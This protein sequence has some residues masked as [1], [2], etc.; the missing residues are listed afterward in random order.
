MQILAPAKLGAPPLLAAMLVAALVLPARLASAAE[1]ELVSD[2]S[3]S[4]AD[5]PD[6]TPPCRTI[7]QAA[8]A[9]QDSGG[10]ASADSQ[11]QAQA[12]G[13]DENC[14]QSTHAT[15]NG[16][17]RFLLVPQMAE[18]PGDPVTVCLSVSRAI[19]LNTEDGGNARFVTDRISAAA[20]GVVQVA[21]P[22]GAA[23]IQGDDQHLETFNCSREITMRIGEH[24]D[25]A[26]GG[27]A[28][29]GTVGI[30]QSQAASSLLI[31]AQVGT[32]P[33]DFEECTVVL[34]TPAFSGPGLGALGLLL[35][36]CGALM[37]RRRRR[38]HSA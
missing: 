4:N 3:S 11:T 8:S 37:V 32:C 28:T 30:G 38:R 7:A 22:K 17:G 14:N 24:L 31:L 33:G 21:L 29:A 19:S 27:T 18:S 15:S 16:A 10:T 6:N 5:T 34:D 20:G 36:A 9:A 25:L 1:F 35:P 23:S 13:E 2:L 12:L 26:A